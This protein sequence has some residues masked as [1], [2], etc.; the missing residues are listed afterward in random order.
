[1]QCPRCCCEM[2]KVHVKNIELDTCDACEGVWFDRD[3]LRQVLDMKIDE[4]YASEISRTME[5]DAD[6]EETPGR[7]EMP[8]PRCGRELT[9]YSYQGYS[10][11]ILDGCDETC[12]IW[13]DD[14]ELKKLFEYMVDANR[15]DPEKEMM[16]VKELKKIKAESDFKSQQLIDSLVMMD[17]RPGLMKIPGMI[18]QGVY[19]MLDRMGI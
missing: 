4:V 8:C 9:R 14:G 1:M 17:N 6:R 12:G 3:E 7:S 18:L 11:I 15:P 2:R 13:L 16:L 5:T 10:G 19:K